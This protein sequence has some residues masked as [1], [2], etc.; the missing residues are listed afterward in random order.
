[1]ND[2]QTLRQRRLEKYGNSKC[3]YC[4]SKKD[5]TF[6]HIIPQALT[7][8]LGMEKNPELENIA[9]LCKDCNGAKG[10]MLKSNDVRTAKLL[11]KYVNRWL[12]ANGPKRK[13]NTYVF[14]NLPVKHHTTVYQ[15]VPHKQ[16]LKSIYEK[17]TN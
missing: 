2:S 5:L 14:R 6:D 13:Q 12:W 16:Y 17:Q 15:F 11:R 10:H 9:V 3:E 7:R 1:M 8:M 4:N